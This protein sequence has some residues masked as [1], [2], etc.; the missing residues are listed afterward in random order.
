VSETI[1]LPET[2]DWATTSPVGRQQGR[3]PQAKGAGQHVLELA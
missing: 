3:A 2:H 1:S